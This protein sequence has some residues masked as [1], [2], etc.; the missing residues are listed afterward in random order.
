[1]EELVK[2]LKS[3]IIDALSLEDISPDDIDADAPLFGSG[4]G[5]DSIDALELIV[6]IEKKYGIKL[7]DRSRGREVFKSI[8]VMAQF[9]AGNPTK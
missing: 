3:E 2:E 9:I 7:Q 1:M 8:N 6:L 5:L 4:L